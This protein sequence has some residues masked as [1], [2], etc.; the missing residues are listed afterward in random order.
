MRIMGKYSWKLFKILLCLKNIVKKNGKGGIKREDK[1]KGEKDEK[2]KK[3]KKKGKERKE[4]KEKVK[5]S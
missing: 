2:R 4:Q 3:G 5:T 1:K